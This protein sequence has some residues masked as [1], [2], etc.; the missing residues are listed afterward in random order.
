MIHNLWIW[1][2][3]STVGCVRS[4]WNEEKKKRSLKH[5]HFHDTRDLAPPYNFI[6]F[7]IYFF[8]NAGN[9]TREKNVDPCERRK[10]FNMRRI[11]HGENKHEGTRKWHQTE[12]SHI[13]DKGHCIKNGRVRSIIISTSINCS[14]FQ[15][16]KILVIQGRIWQWQTLFPKDVVFP[17][18]K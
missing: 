2:C 18:S 8:E 10:K 4:H 15:K 11:F 6:Q 1:K 17:I 14:I 7:R 12:N 9:V 5:Q 13:F 16:I 3:Q